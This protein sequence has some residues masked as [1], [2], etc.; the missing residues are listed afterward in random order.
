MESGKSLLKLTWASF[1]RPSGDEDSSRSRGAGGRHVGRV[2]NAGYEVRVVTPDE[3]AVYRQVSHR[4]RY[5]RPGRTRGSRRTNRR[6]DRSARVDDQFLQTAVDANLEKAVGYLQRANR[7]S[8]R[9]GKAWSAASL[10]RTV[11]AAA[12]VAL[13]WVVILTAH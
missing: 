5:A 2:P 7:L 1:W 8:P 13:S 11:H 9:T 12:V 10:R 3:Y 4:A 6:V